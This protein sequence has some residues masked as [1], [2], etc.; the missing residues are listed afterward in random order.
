MKILEIQVYRGANLWAPV[1]VIRFVVDIGEL[2]ECP[3]HIIPG[4]CERLSATMPT[5]VKHS[6]SSGEPGGLF[7]QVPYHF[8]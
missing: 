2:R 5:L 4:F 6:C 3:T 7:Q 1:P 8:A